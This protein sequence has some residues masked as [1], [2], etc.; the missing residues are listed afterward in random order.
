MQE[1]FPEKNKINKKKNSKYQ[2]IYI[3]E[4]LIYLYLIINCIHFL[5]HNI[6]D[7]VRQNNMQ[8]MVQISCTSHN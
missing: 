8:I 3:I 5:L 7:H 2:N 4:V 1:I 6:F